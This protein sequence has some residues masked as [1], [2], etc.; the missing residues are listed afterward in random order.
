MSAAHRLGLS[1][2]QCSPPPARAER[3]VGARGHHHVHLPGRG[4]HG[5]IHKV[6]VRLV[7]DLEPAR[8]VLDDEAVLPGAPRRAHEAARG[9][10]EADVVEG[11]R[12]AVRQG[13]DELEAQL[14]RNLRGGGRRDDGD[15]LREFLERRA[16]RVVVEALSKE[17]ARGAGCAMVRVCPA[18]DHPIQADGLAAGAG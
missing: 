3:D 10:A 2:A 14:L 18:A 6:H 13:E 5:R 1:A 17:G 16:V 7:V 9:G 15:V 8:H 12:L 11:D 4:L